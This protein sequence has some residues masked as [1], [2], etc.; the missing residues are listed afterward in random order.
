MKIKVISSTIF[1]II[2]L[3]LCSCKKEEEAQFFDPKNEKYHFQDNV[4]WVQ[5]ADNGFFGPKNFILTCIDEDG[6]SIFRIPDAS[7]SSVSYFYNDVALLYGQYVINKEGIII[8]DLQKE[9]DVKIKM[10]D[11]NYFD[12]FIIVEKKVNDVDMTGILNSNIE[13]VVEPTTKFNDI[14][15]KGV[16]LYYISG[17]YFDALTNEMITE[18]EY[19]IRH[20]ERSFPDSGII[21]LNNQGYN[22]YIY[23]SSIS[24]GVIYLDND[25]YITG[26]YDRNLI[27]LLDLSDYNNV[28]ILSEVKNSKCLILFETEQNQ[29]L[30]GLINFNGNFLFTY[31]YYLY[32]GYDKNTIDFS[33]CYYD[34]D[35]NYYIKEKNE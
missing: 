28:S 20:F 18:D 30:V 4:A 35:G 9:L 17:E 1:L 19:L 21:F 32:N 27:L 14:E 6:N 24:N 33:D 8:H 23:H 34:W 12:G 5:Q 26:L 31:N 15:P 22:K 16:F 29:K 25:S 7:L 3:L 2:V 10:F 13:W 11:D